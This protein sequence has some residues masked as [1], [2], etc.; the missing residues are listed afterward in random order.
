LFTFAA[1]FP[2]ERPDE[3][4]Y[5]VAGYQSALGFQQNC[6]LLALELGDTLD[7]RCSFAGWGENLYLVRNLYNLRMERYGM[8]ILGVNI[9]ELFAPLYS[10]G[11]M[12]GDGLF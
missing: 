1:Y 10:P 12:W 5:T 8:L 7:T 2:I 4:M 9:P 11:Q 6:L 3:F